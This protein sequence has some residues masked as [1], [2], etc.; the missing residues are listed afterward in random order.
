MRVPSALLAAAILSACTSVTGTPAETCDGTWRGVDS[1]IVAPDGGSAVPLP[2]TCIRQVDEKRI[3]IGF[4]MPPGPT[5]Y[6]LDAVQ[7][8]ES[9]DAVSVRLM[10]RPDDN[11]TSGA[12]PDDPGRITTEVD[13]QSPVADRELLDAAAQ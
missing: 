12:C 9:S 2:A 11:P 3:R 10:V 13:L 1:V 6:L 4:S 5:C 8:A 7:V